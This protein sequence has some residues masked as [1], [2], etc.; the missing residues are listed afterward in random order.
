MK[1]AVRLISSIFA[2]TTLVGCGSRS[3][4]RFSKVAIPEENRVDVEFRRLDKELTGLNYAN[5]ASEFAKL[6]DV[7]A[8]NDS[9][10]MNFLDIYTEA[11]L[12]IGN[13]DQMETRNIIQKFATGKPYCEFFQDADSV[14]PDMSAEKQE[15]DNAFSILKTNL[16]DMNVP[17]QYVAIVSGFYSN[18]LCTKSSLGFSLEYYLG[19]NYPNYKYV[20]GL[21]DYMI[22]NYRREKLVSDGVFCWLSTEYEFKESAPTLLQKIIY[23]GKLV[24]LTSVSLPNEDLHTILG[25]TP[26]QYEWC[27]QNE[28]QMWHYMAEYKHLF[29]TDRLTVGKYCDPAPSTAFF[30][31]DSPGRSGL[32]VGYNIVKAYLDANTNVTLQ[33]L[34]NNNDAS[35]ILEMSGY[36]PK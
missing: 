13:V 8:A 26:D 15:L 11:V 36:N 10:D 31:Q 20:D 23:L 9:S 16:P 5:S 24:Y 21:Y 18:V 29:N 22:C 33:E 3:E 25:Y 30:P 35:E 17:K 7:Y 6:K 2:A 32:F 34:M 1:F 28:A 4:D 12:N 27:C 14:F 19:A